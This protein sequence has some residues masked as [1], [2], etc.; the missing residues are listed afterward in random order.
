MKPFVGVGKQFFA[1]P[2]LLELIAQLSVEPSYYFFRWT[3]EVSGILEQQP[4]DKHFP[5]MA[6]QMFNQQCELR[7]QP[8]H[9][10]LY[11][12]L[13]LSI[14]GEHPDFKLIGEGNWQIEPRNN[15]AFPS[16]AYPAYGYR[17]EETRFPKKFIYPDSLDVRIGEQN[18]GKPKLGQRYFIDDQTSAVQFV[19]LTLEA[20][21]K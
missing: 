11:Q 15:S 10:H 14:A 12:V 6:G 3:H 7:W 18:T 17:R 13:L 9:N 21:Q 16:C 5:M 20:V 19:A 4:T 1:V 8:K 2:Q